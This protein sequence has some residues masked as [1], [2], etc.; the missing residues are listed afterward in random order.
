MSKTG[1][2][3]ALLAALVVVAGCNLPRGA[4]LKSEIVGNDAKAAEELDIAVEEV[5][6]ASV[7]KINAWPST[8]WHGHFHWFSANR[9]PDYNLISPGDVLNLVI[10]DSSDNSLLTGDGEQATPMTD[11]KVSPTGTVFVPYA[12]NVKVS[13]LTESQARE[14]LQSKVSEV[15]PS[16]QVQL[17]VK[18]GENNTVYLVSGVP[19][20]GPVKLPNRNYNILALLSEGGGI[21]SNFENPVVKL[22]RGGSTYSIPADELFE[23]ARKNVVLRGGDQIIVEEDER[24]FTAIG[25]VQ[26]EQVLNFPKSTLTAMEALSLMGGLT[27]ERAN[28]QG[29]LILREFDSDQLRADGTGPSNEYVVF[30]IDLASAD[31]LFGA[32]KFQVRPGDIVVA[33]ESAV[34]PAQAVI[35][36]IGS[37]FAIANVF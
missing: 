32:G 25:A 30:T 31:G 27:D 24:T 29:V 9:G 8:G 22:I 12:S 21:S 7:K 28:P 16:A 3:S 18:Q 33:T 34:K 1:Y 26:S 6:R 13:G 10:W 11:L 23:D 19:N 5:T 17:V 37:A 15:A 36:L 2:V 14:L 35:A 20:S 4:P